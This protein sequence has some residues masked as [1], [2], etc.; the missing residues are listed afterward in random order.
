MARFRPAQEPT[1]QLEGISNI[2]FNDKAIQM[3]ATVISLSS[4]G[5]HPVPFP[6]CTVDLFFTID[7]PE[8]EDAEYRKH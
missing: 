2:S 6:T 4:P 7:W 1:K 5:G 8:L 3:M